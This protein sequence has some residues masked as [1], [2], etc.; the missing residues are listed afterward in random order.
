[1]EKH[2]VELSAAVPKRSSI[3]IS[4]PN[5]VTVFVSL[6]NAYK[7]QMLLSSAG[8]CGPS[9]HDLAVEMSSRQQQLQTS[10]AQEVAVACPARCQDTNC[11]LVNIIYNIC[12]KGAVINIPMNQSV[13]VILNHTHLFI[14]FNY[15][16]K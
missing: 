5:H 16:F 12:I 11:N 13:S 2:I 8:P 9:W 15:I 1:M 14:L 4:T 6:L 3:E 7:C 10:P